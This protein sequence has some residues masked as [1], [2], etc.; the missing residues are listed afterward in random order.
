MPKEALCF[1]YPVNTFVGSTADDFS[2]WISLFASTY[3]ES[4]CDVLLTSSDMHLEKTS[5]TLKELSNIKII[6]FPSFW[7]IQARQ[8]SILPNCASGCRLVVLSHLHFS[9]SL[10]NVLAKNFFTIKRKIHLK[11]L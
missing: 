9:T 4:H 10:P 11:R 3:S 8:V 7:A 2:N 6:L 5:A 1:I